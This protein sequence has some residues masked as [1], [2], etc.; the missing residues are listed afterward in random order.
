MASETPRRMCRSCK[1]PARDGKKTCQSC[2]DKQSAYSRKHQ[3]KKRYNRKYY[4]SKKPVPYI[5]S[6]EHDWRQSYTGTWARC[7][8]CKKVKHT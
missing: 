4:Q 7:T 1:W 3:A 8:L 5:R 6:C 2:A